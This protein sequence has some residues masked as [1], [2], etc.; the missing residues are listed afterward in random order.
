MGTDARWRRCTAVIVGRDIVHEIDARGAFVVM[1]FVG[2]QI[3]L[4]VTVVAQN[5]SPTG[6][7]NEE[8]AR[9]R[10]ELGDP[11]TL[12]ATRVKRWVRST[13]I[14]S[15]H[16]D[17]RVDRVIRMLRQ[18]PLDTHSTSLV[19]LSKIAGLSP[20]RFAHVFSESFGVP[21]RPYMRWLRLMRAVRELVSGRSV[22]H[23]AHIAGFADA[24][25]LTRTCR[26]TLGV[27]PGILTKRGDP[28]GT[29]HRE[30]PH[31]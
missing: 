8:A 4:G 11:R 27:S 26:R 25:H 22:T 17:S 30:S 2:A 10:R 31:A 18:Q 14:R 24:A 9:W 20:S 13:L 12:D 6:L 7:S 29:P 16:A 15:A 21:V 5:R 19:E 28:S 1:A 23:A 3:Q